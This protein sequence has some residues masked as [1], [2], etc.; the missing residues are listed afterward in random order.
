MFIKIKIKSVLPPTYL[1]TA[2]VAMLMVHFVFPTEIIINYPWS[3]FGCGPLAM[4][5]ILNLIAD[6]AFKKHN[7]TV[8]PFDESAALITTGVF[9]ISRHPMYLGMVLILLG[10]AILMGSLMPFFVVIVFA[11][12]ME[13]VFIKTEERMLEQKFGSVWL[14]YKKKVRRW[15]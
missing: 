3:L 15:L 1:F 10:I 4:G 13:V 9:R 12:L 5:I 14:E 6:A 7:T 11:T 8:K 2:L